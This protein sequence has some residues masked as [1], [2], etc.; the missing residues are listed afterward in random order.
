MKKMKRIN[1]LPANIQQGIGQ[2]GKSVF[3][4]NTERQNAE[5]EYLS[6]MPVHQT[7]TGD[8]PFKPGALTQMRINK[9]SGQ[10]K[11]QEVMD[12]LVM[13][14]V[15]MIGNIE[16]ILSGHRGSQN[17][18][19]AKTQLRNL[20]EA[21]SNYKSVFEMVNDGMSFDEFTREDKYVE[22]PSLSETES[23]QLDHLLNDRNYTPDDIAQ[24]PQLQE[25]MSRASGKQLSKLN[26]NARAVD[27]AMEDEDR[28][29]LQQEQRNAQ[30][31][32]N[33][34]ME[35]A[36]YQD[37]MSKGPKIGRYYGPNIDDDA[38][39]LMARDY[40]K[41]DD[42]KPDAMVQGLMGSDSIE[43][44][45]GLMGML[46]M[47][48][49]LKNAGASDDKL[50]AFDDLGHRAR[51]DKM[52]RSYKKE[53]GD[54]KDMQQLM[55]E[56]SEAEFNKAPSMVE[57]TT[58]APKKR[59]FLAGLANKAK[60]KTQLAGLKTQ[61]AGGD[62]MAGLSGKYSKNLKREI[63]AQEGGGFLDLIQKSATQVADTAGQG[64]ESAGKAWG[65]VKDTVKAGGEFLEGRYGDKAI[66]NRQADQEAYGTL[67]Q[68]EGW[69]DMSQEEQQQAVN[70][71]VQGLSD[72]KMYG[73]EWG[74]DE[75]TGDAGETGNVDISGGEGWT[76]AG[77]VAGDTVKAAG[78]G[79]LG[80]A[81]LGVGGTLF[82]G[83][84]AIEGGKKLW[85]KAT[86][87]K[88]GILGGERASY[89]DFASGKERGSWLQRLGR[90]MNTAGNFVSMAGEDVPF[91]S[92]G[93]NE[94]TG[95]KKRDKPQK[96]IKQTNVN[97]RLNEQVE[98]PPEPGR[99]DD[100][101]TLQVSDDIKNNKTVNTSAG[102]LAPSVILSKIKS[103]DDLKNLDPEMLKT[104]Q[105]SL[106]EAGYDM[107]KSGVEGGGFDGKF[108]PE[109]Q[110][111]FAEYMK[112]QTMSPVE[113][114]ETEQQPELGTVG[115]GS[116]PDK[117]DH[118]MDGSD[119]LTFQRG[120]FISKM[121]AYQNGGLV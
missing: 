19:V 23:R 98:G 90:G 100:G 16:N 76:K 67:S 106:A 30:L 56:R 68:M 110:A 50:K 86:D 7:P 88:S 75:F 43:D 49:E 66:K 27:M 71:R 35:E 82:A 20:G 112:S 60:L 93:N 48:R 13:E 81:G 92:Y 116:D 15:Q 28:A 1:A 62:L 44:D 22:P 45:L 64:W 32:H 39:N 99:K 97:V 11:N 111:A 41:Y 18:D 96:G 105:A 74:E 85:D 118:I 89:E 21:N 72:N 38:M 113:Q 6:S 103:P 53:Y 33:S 120:G 61:K 119:G 29:I 8:G 3:N 84:K 34:Q 57:R 69:D 65:G 5:S 42:N 54:K 79:L 80:A 37:K 26:A 95:I 51:I 17:Y 114:A 9:E 117:Y 4:R 58:E 73:D 52:E 78:V 115:G 104:V 2:E 59:G 91:S 70:T 94:L 46:N 107:T 14:E 109:T 25:I 101:Q 63:N 121:R 36:A 77:A 83:K 108:G 31:K 24:N 87:E 55:A 10:R 102:K 40:V 12:N 47:R